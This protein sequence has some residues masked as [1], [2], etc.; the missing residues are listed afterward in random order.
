LILVLRADAAHRGDS[1]VE[2]GLSPETNVLVEAGQ[3]DKPLNL[4]KKR[5][6]RRKSWDALQRIPIQRISKKRL[7]NKKMNG[8]HKDGFLS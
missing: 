7:Q 6:T 2:R 8:P 1:P 3:R 5:K 4:E